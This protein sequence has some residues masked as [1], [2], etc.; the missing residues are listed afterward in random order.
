MLYSIDRF[1]GDIAVLIDEDGNRLDVARTELSDDMAAGDMVRL[2]AGA[3][4]RDDDATAARRARLIEL[5]NRLR[6]RK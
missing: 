5:Q 6:K 3:F 2:Q 4:Q 1:E